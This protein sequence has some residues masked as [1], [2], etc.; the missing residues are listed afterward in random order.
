MHRYRHAAMNAAALALMLAA[1]LSHAESPMNVMFGGTQASSRSGYTY[2][3]AIMPLQGSELGL[4]AYGKAIASWLNYRYNSSELGPV[5]EI[6]ASGPGVEVGAGY[7]WR[8]ERGT[9]DLSATVGYRELHVTPF[10]PANQKSG[11][12]LTLNPQLAASTRLSGTVDADLLANYA[13]GLGSS[14]ARARIGTKPSGSWRAGV[15]AVFLDGHNYSI[16]QQGVFLSLPIDAG[17]SIEFIVG[18]SKPRDDNASAYAG[19]AFARNF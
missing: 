7:A 2:L 9:L 19:I 15:E 11:G 18:R 13:I 10:V 17:T 12:V 3:G 6:D 1:P 8:D 5:T 4:G 14:W 16:R